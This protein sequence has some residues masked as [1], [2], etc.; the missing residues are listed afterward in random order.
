MRAANVVL[1]LAVASG[2]AIIRH[3]RGEGTVRRPS[4]AGEPVR[5]NVADVAP[6]LRKRH[7][8]A[9]RW[10]DPIDDLHDE[11]AITRY[12]D[13]EVCLQLVEHRLPQKS[14]LPSWML[15]KAHPMAAHRLTLKS[16]DGT[17]LKKPKVSKLTADPI[18]R[19]YLANREVVVGRDR[20]T[21]S[22]GQ[23]T[24][25]VDRTE[26]RQVQLQA[27]LTRYSGEACFATSHPFVQPGTTWIRLSMQAKLYAN[28]YTLLLK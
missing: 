23:P 12:T 10:V 9:I 24:A 21:N 19:R 16:S 8:D 7:S 22:A 18:T 5:S 28:Q 26:V 15:G 2:C 14:S 4:G 17:K 11:L 20:V 1:V 13:A 3:D 25:T 6:K 27:K